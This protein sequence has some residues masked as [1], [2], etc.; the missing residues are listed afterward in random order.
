MCCESSEALKR[1]LEDSMRWYRREHQGRKVSQA[2]LEISNDI[3][4]REQDG[5]IKGA[6][7]R[8]K[9]GS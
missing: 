4:D 3:R 5:D 6:L 7:V 9:I 2:F 8:W 1:K